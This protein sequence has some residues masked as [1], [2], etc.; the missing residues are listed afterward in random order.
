[1]S[2]RVGIAETCDGA[3]LAPD[4]V[5]EDRPDAVLGVR[6]YLVAGTLKRSLPFSASPACAMAGC[7]AHSRV[8]TIE[9]LQLALD[10]S[11]KMAGAVTGQR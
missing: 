7:I 9:P 2:V 5:I 8:R 10:V 4:D 1:M 11:H 3:C 6:S